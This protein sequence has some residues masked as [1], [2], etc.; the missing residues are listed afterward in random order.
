[1]NYSFEIFRDYTCFQTIF[2]VYVRVLL[3]YN[4]ITIFKTYTIFIKDFN[5]D[6]NILLNISINNTF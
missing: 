6:I 1:M 4:Y 5:L 3:I 2:V